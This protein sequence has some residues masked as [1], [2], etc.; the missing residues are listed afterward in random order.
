MSATVVGLDLQACL[1]RPTAQ[2][3]DAEA[4]EIILTMA[5]PEAIIALNARQ[6]ED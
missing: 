1:A 4:L 6:S 2:G 5:E 3:C